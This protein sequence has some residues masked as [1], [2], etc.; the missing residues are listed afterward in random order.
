[1]YQLTMNV[2]GDGAVTLPSGVVISNATVNISTPPI[3]FAIYWVWT[4][5]LVADYQ[6]AS[7]SIVVL[8]LNMTLTAEFSQDADKFDTLS[9]DTQR[10]R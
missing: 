8:S 6:S 5:D 1:M 4:G 7:S 9:N 2:N 3:A 10:L